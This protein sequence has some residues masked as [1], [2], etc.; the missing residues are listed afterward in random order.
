M[1]ASLCV[2]TV[3]HVRCE[4]RT[5]Q[6]HKQHHTYEAAAEAAP[7]DD[8]FDEAPDQIDRSGQASKWQLYLVA[9]AER[10]YLIRAFDCSI[11]AYGWLTQK[12]SDAWAWITY[13]DNAAYDEKQERE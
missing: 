12:V 6:T 9:I 10:L 5:V 7:V 2:V 1:L 11:R 3:S 4:S 8:F 13:T